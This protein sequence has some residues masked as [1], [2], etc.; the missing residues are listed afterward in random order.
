LFCDACSSALRR[1][2]QL[3]AIGGIVNM[4]PNGRSARPASDNVRDNGRG[5][6]GS[7]GTDAQDVLAFDEAP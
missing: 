1:E 5:A 4:R 7:E 3:D 6:K 2:P